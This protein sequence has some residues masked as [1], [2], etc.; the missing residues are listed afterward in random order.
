MHSYATASRVKGML[1]QGYEHRVVAEKCK[2]SLQ[3]VEKLWLLESDELE[4]RDRWDKNAYLPDHEEILLKCAEI[5]KGWDAETM[6]SR[7]VA[8]HRLRSWRA[9]LIPLGETDFEAM[10]IQ[11]C[12]P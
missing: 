7:S 8:N 12:E 6:A 10:T 9:P 3:Y 2:V 4:Y 5:R 1:R 11:E